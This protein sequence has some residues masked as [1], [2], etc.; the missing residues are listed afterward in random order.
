MIVSVWPDIHFRSSTQRS[1]AEG[2]TQGFST[3]VCS[4]PPIMISSLAYISALEVQVEKFP[5]QEIQWNTTTAMSK[6]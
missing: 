3:F 2:P 4:W 1:E 6:S 5:Q